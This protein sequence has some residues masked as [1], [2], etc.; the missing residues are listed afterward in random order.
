M[1]TA[2]QRHMWDL[3]NS[4][5]K[6]PKGAVRRGATVL[7]LGVL[8]WIGLATFYASDGSDGLIRVGETVG[9]IWGLVG[10][11]LLIL[12]V[13]A[14]II[15]VV[16]IL[17]ALFRPT[18]RVKCP[19][20]STSHKLYFKVRSYVCTG[21]ACVLRLP[22]TKTAKMIK[23]TCPQCS[24][25]WSTTTDREKMQC[26]SCGLTIDMDDGRAS[27]VITKEKC[28][29]CATPI[30]NSIY[31]CPKCGKLNSKPHE[32]ERL[33]VDGDLHE[34]MRTSLPPTVDGMDAISLMANSGIGFL[35]RATWSAHSTL[36]KLKR[37]EENQQK[38][39]LN[40]QIELLRAISYA[41]EYL[42]EAV[43][44]KPLLAPAVLSIL[45]V[46]N[47]CL[48]LTIAGAVEWDSGRLYGYLSPNASSDEM[49]ALRTSYNSYKQITIDLSNKHNIVVKRVASEIGLTQNEVSAKLWPEPI[50]DIRL[51][52]DGQ[53]IVAMNRQI[54][55]D[56]ITPS[57]ASFSSISEVHIPKSALVL[58][59]GHH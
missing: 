43:V 57:A 53:S 33:E 35:V 17:V 38:Q 13:L 4:S 58:I 7:F 47:H 25:E 2:F 20:C 5:P 52:R 24:T 56:Q 26:F 8:C 37:L 55:H 22:F 40:D 32:M 42:H 23:V 16:L 49:I 18:R 19:Y 1:E 27:L 36:Q 44:L 45:Q 12:S 28:G 6:T 11:L 34:L 10:L 54:M 50:L 15:G 14:P 59:P 48:T 51:S 9:D 41:M 29:E 3:Q 21:C 30:A 39:R 46:F 31:F